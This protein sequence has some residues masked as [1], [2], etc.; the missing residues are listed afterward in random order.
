MTDRLIVVGQITLPAPAA[1]RIR[2]AAPGFRLV[3][4]PEPDE[5]LIATAEVYAGHLEPDDIAR[6]GRLRWNHLWTAGADADLSEEM[7]AA[8]AVVLTSSAGNGA[9]PLAEHALLLMLM[10]DRDVPRWLAAQRARTWDRYPHRELAGQTVGIVGMGAAGRDLAEKCHAFH[11]RVVGLRGRPTIPAAGVE[12]MYG[13]EQIT[14]FAAEC[15]YLVVAAPLT[16]TTRGMIDQ[17]VF[18]AMRPTA[19]IINIS[20]G[21]IVDD[22]AMLAAVREHRIAGAGLDAH[23][24]EPLPA[25]S[26][27]WTEPGVIVTPHNGATTPQTVARAV[28]VFVDNVE[29]YA[30]RRPLVN[31][32]D[33]QSGYAFG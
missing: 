15:D 12:R 7:R 5:T 24:V 32:V 26:P 13:P 18:A 2:T 1:D 29:R 3:V 28:D 6:A 17:R 9:I 14:Q 20:R 23:R 11:M 22:E 30:Q 31:V 27:W 4:A 21:E 16:P 19:T 33:K 10:L 25:D 8:D